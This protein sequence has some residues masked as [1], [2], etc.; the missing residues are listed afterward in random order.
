MQTIPYK[1]KF[2]TKIGGYP[3]MLFIV[4]RFKEGNLQRRFWD[5]VRP[6]DGSF[7]KIGE[8]EI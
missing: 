6:Y 4:M 3:A 1:F 8:I 2:N 7:S 5:C